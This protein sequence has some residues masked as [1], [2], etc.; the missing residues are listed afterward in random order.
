MA[1]AEV[2]HGGDKNAGG[3]I[4]SVTTTLT[5]LR[6]DDVDPSGQGLGDVLRRADHVHDGDT[7][8]Q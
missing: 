4:A 7:C 2:Y 5:A 3:D 1:L 8:A 6:T